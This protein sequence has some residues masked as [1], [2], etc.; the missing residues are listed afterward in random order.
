[1]LPLESKLS[2]RLVSKTFFGAATL[3]GRWIAGL[4][5]TNPGIG[6]VILDT[7]ALLDSGKY[8]FN[9]FISQTSSSVQRVNFE[10]RNSTDTGTIQSFL[11][12]IPANSTFVWQPNIRALIGIQERLRIVTLTSLGIGN[13]IQASMFI[14]LTVG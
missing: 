4:Q 2:K 13:I 1:M 10:R 11:L 5:F 14:S 7:G 6:T 8:V 12:L 9:V 3:E